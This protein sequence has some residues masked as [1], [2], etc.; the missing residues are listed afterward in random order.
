MHSGCPSLVQRAQTAGR[1]TLVVASLVLVLSLLVTPAAAQTPN[2][3]DPPRTAQEAEQAARTLSDTL[4]LAPSEPVAA[5]DV[6]R[7]LVD[8]DQTASEAALARLVAVD[9]AGKAH[10]ALF[11]SLG[12]LESAR[13][14]V[15]RATTARDNAKARLEEERDRLSQLTVNAYTSGG[16]VSS[17]QYRSLLGGDT[18]DPAHG[19]AVIFEQVLARQEQVTEQASKRAVATRKSLVRARDKLTVAKAK[20]DSRA[21]F[22][23]GAAGVQA[24]AER[25]HEQAAVELVRARVRLQSGRLNG[26]VSVDA[27]IIGMPRLGAGDLASWFAASSYRP[28]VSTPID[29][30]AKWFIEEGS[31]E[32]IRGDIAFAQAVLETGGFANN[33]SVLANNFSGIGHC[34]LCPSGWV[35]ASP[36]LGVRAQ[37]QLLKSYA[38]RKPQYVND[39]VD[40]RLRGP[41]GCCQTWGDLTT[42][43]AT[44]PTYGPKVM[45]IYTSMVEHALRRRALGQGFDEAGPGSAPAP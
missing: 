8:A 5:D 11:E 14:V 10:V 19:R 45:L 31:A 21:E 36:R 42:V 7:D 16:D 22:D 12:K 44:D 30:Y 37:I 40:R 20:A 15:A 29:D 34:D 1:R 6:F 43:W 4:A 9:A 17:E 33:D 26:T 35:F 23:R 2:P 24:E 27:A 38:I 3:P 13:K 28:R 18:T 39:L 25:A 32:G 41:A